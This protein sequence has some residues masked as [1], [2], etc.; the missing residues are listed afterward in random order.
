VRRAGWEGW[1]AGLTLLALLL[2][3]AW[4]LGFA[5]FL[6]AARRAE[7]LPAQADGIVVLTGGADRV[8]AGLRLLD[9]GR[10]PALLISGAGRGAGL[11]AIAQGQGL[12]Q[13]DLDARD[14]AA[15]IAP[16]I[17][18][19]Y[20]A[21]TTFGNAAETASWARR[22]GARSLI[23]VTAGYHM[24]RALLELGRALPGVALH[25]A[26]VQSPVLRERAGPGVLRLLA[27]EFDKWLATRLG[28]AAALLPGRGA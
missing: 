7:P 1:L 4:S 8:A 28:L 15:R 11:V 27:G 25:P 26:P 14:L 20:A 5:G 21:Q 6:G 3:A 10:A 16:R 22:I 9:E 13:A 24:P 17:A 23:V 2:G 12:A 18:L 19:G